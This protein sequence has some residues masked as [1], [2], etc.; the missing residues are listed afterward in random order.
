MKSCKISLGTAQIKP[1]RYQHLSIVTSLRFPWLSFSNILNVCSECVFFLSICKALLVWPCL[2]ISWIVLDDIYLY[3]ECIF[4]NIYLNNVC[5]L[6]P[7]GGSSFWQFEHLNH[8]KAHS[9]KN[10][11]FESHK[12]GNH[13][14][15]V[16]H[17]PTSP[18]MG[19]WENDR[20]EDM[21]K[22]H[23]THRCGVDGL[24]RE[25]LTQSRIAQVWTMFLDVSSMGQITWSWCVIVLPYKSRTSEARR[26]SFQAWHAKRI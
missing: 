3:V 14:R 26:V 18:N 1:P 8:L 16:A 7:L 23:P 17:N 12:S 9:C 15:K 4:L 10:S 11:L 19:D 25:E 22:H 2:R 13:A 5:S 20:I 6:E 21:D 24:V